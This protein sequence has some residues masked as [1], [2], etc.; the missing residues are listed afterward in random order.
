MNF[1]GFDIE[2]HGEGEGYGLQ[3]F[4]VKEGAARITSAALVNANGDVLWAALEPDLKLL[5]AAL[6]ALPED[7]VLIGWNTLFDVAWLIAAGLEDV[8]RELDWADGEV[9]RRTL[10]NDTSTYKEKS[11]GLKATVTKYLPE[12][13]G[14]EKGVGGDFSVIDETL[15]EYNKLDSQLTAKLGEIFVEQMTQ[16]DLMLAEIICGGIVPFARAWVDG[17]LIDTEALKTWGDAVD[18]SLAESF[19]SVTD[20]SDIEVTAKMLQSSQQLKK[21]LHGQGVPVVSTNKSELTKYI[22]IPLVKAVLDF[23]AARTATTKFIT[24]LDNALAYNGDGSVRPSARLWNTYTGRVGYTSK[25]KLRKTETT[26]GVDLPTG[27]AIH[28]FPRKTEARNCIIAPDGYALV[29]CDFATQESRLLCDFSGD[30]VLYKIFTDDLDFHAYMAAIIA[31][32][33]YEEIAGRLAEKNAEAKNFRQYAK[34]ANLSCAYRTSWK[35]LIEQARTQYGV[36]LD[37]VMAQKLHSLFRQVYKSVPQYW[38]DAIHIAKCNGYAE[39]RGGRKVLLS[40]WSRDRAWASES[41]AINFPIQATGADMKFLGLKLVAPMLAPND[42]RY[43]LDLHDALFFI[44]PDTSAG[45]ELANDIRVIL[46]NLPYQQYFGWTPRVKLP[47]DLKI[48][49]AWGSLTE[50][51]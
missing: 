21:F 34:V 12:Y 11:Y 18:S 43:L 25:T 41:T 38:N 13:S 16:K 2:T 14:Y 20:I 49:R 45:H 50:I 26:K 7:T 27:V 36:I 24:G 3:P 17:I 19:Q 1:I 32:V 4:R 46:S 31:E 6:R 8:V 42:A 22:H 40:N 33:S 39:S 47:V 15:L 29:E 35:R 48:G 23:K 10:E 5:E 44:V 9:F 30:E 37:D 51:K 28:Q